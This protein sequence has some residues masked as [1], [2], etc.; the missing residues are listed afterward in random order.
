MLERR[1]QSEALTLSMRTDSSIARLN[2]SRRAFFCAGPGLYAT[3]RFG[4]ALLRYAPPAT[5]CVVSVSKMLSIVESDVIVLVPSNS[6]RIVRE[7]V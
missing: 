3:V 2:H 5:A 1:D 7:G 4:G 6:I